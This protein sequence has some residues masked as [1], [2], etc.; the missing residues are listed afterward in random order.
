MTSDVKLVDVP[1]PINCD[2]PYPSSCKLDLDIGVLKLVGSDLVKPV[3]G[4]QID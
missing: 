2:N 1:L 3:R 4:A